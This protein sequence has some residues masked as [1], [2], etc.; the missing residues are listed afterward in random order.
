MPLAYKA[1]QPDDGAP[2]HWSHQAC[3]ARRS[4]SSRTTDSGHAEM[5][6]DS[7][8][9]FGNAPARTPAYH[10][11]R[12]TGMI[13]RTSGSRSRRPTDFVEA[14]VRAATD[15]IDGAEGD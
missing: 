3:A 13:F 11:E 14:M 5:R 6:A 1:S 9:G 15:A 7:R 2:K 12:L 10:V 4:A 8:T